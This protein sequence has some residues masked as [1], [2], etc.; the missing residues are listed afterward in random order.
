ML[1]TLNTDMF[2]QNYEI[3][4]ILKEEK[5]YHLVVQIQMNDVIVDEK[6]T[7]PIKLRN[8]GEFLVDWLYSKYRGQF[9]RFSVEER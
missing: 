2:G 8:P 9:H 6:L 1:A 5:P 4:L 7:T 3:T